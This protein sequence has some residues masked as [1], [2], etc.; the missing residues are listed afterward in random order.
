VSVQARK[1]WHV[2]RGAFRA[3]G[4]RWTPFDAGSTNQL[5]RGEG[6]S[7]EWLL[8]WYRYPQPGIQPE[9]EVAQFLRQQGYDGVPEFGARLDEQVEGV[10]G[11]AVE[12]ANSAWITRAFVQRWEAGRSVWDWMLERLR[13]HQPD[14]SYARALG[15]RVGEL[16]TAL[17]SGSPGT[18][19]QSFAWDVVSH[20]RWVA[21]LRN[22]VAQWV[23]ALDEKRPEAVSESAWWQLRRDCVDGENGWKQ[24]LE[25][26][27]KLQLNG[28]QS[29]IHGDLH[30][31]QILQRTSRC[32]GYGFCFVDFEGEP[33]RPL[34]ERR[35]LDTPLRDVAGMCRSFAYAA[36]TVNASESMQYA[37][38]EEFIQGWSGA[39]PACGGDWRRIL[40][41]LIWEKAVYEALYELGHRPDWLWIP[42]KA[43]GVSC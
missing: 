24:R 25:N 3:R 31:G 11:F 13:A 17:A 4:T 42:L 5:W 39:A 35:L 33:M 16:H 10:D 9:P 23:A 32:G 37:L 26:L 38:Q 1:R 19:F 30:L 43:L 20:R 34:A 36:A 14:Y 18:A 27:V 22:G 6:A 41:G 40:D 29:R 28:V 15:Q 12:S 7:G 8:K 2:E 21:R